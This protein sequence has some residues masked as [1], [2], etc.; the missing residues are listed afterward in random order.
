[1]S[2]TLAF[3]CITPLAVVGT[4][5]Q[6]MSPFLFPVLMDLFQFILT[7]D[8]FFLLVVNVQLGRKVPVPPIS[9]KRMKNLVLGMTGATTVIGTHSYIIFPCNHF[10]SDEGKRKAAGEY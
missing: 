4:T 7:T 9:K 3:V 1:M 8:I 2:S 10:K 6:F 5:F